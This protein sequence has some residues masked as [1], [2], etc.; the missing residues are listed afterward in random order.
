MAHACLLLLMNSCLRSDACVQERL[1]QQLLVSARADAEAL[2]Q[3]LQVGG[4][5]CVHAC[6]VWLGVCKP[7]RAAAGGLSNFARAAFTS[8]CLP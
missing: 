3:Q 5:L 8:L 1:L 7:G 6:C 2:G 4:G